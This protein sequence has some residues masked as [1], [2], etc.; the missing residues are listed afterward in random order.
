MKSFASPVGDLVP[1]TSKTSQTFIYK[2][3]QF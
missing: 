1:L 2:C 3:D